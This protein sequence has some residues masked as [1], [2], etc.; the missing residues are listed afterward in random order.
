MRLFSIPS[1]E[2]GVWYLGVFPIR[3]YAFCI[4]LG[5]V[6]AIWLGERRWQARGG[7]P[8]LIMDLA[9]WMVPFGVIGGRIYH[10]ITSWSAYF[11]P[12]G[13]PA[14]ALRI[15]EGGLGIWGAVV[16]G[17]V[18]GWIG[19][20]RHKVPLPMV[21]DAIAPGIVLAQG[22]GRLGNWFNNE[23]YGSSTTLPWG[24]Q[25][26]EWDQ[27][28]GQALLDAQG[29]ARLLPGLY[30]PAFLYELLW[31]VGVCLVLLWMDRR[32]QIGHGRL[33]AWY[34]ALYTAGRFWIE[35]LRT[36]PATHVLGLRLNVWTSIV[37]FVGAV[38]YIV[39]SARQRPGRESMVERASTS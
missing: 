8:G 34:V 9:V 25:I 18:G 37:V 32:W 28:A 12:D 23:L 29:H 3:A 16:L 38:T 31:N 4:L 30:H 21:G 22:I 1:P 26:H 36:D 27:A 33:F 35:M 24:L 7:Q 5:I 20:R 15:W 17:G 13:D 11:G 2:Q 39:I 14:K 19:A 10:V 6:A